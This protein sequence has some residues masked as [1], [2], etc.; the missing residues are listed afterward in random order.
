MFTFRYP[1]PPN[2]PVGRAEEGRL[3]DGVETLLEH[4]LPLE[5]LDRPPIAANDNQLAWPFI[6]FPEDWCG[7]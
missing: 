1:E 5:I 4:G 2:D 7:P 3:F 6:P